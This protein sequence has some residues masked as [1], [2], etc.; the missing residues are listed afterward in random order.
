[1]SLRPCAICAFAM[2]FD[3]RTKQREG[4]ILRPTVDAASQATLRK[5]IHMAALIADGEGPEAVLAVHRVIAWHVRIQGRKTVYQPIVGQT[6][7]SSIDLHGCTETLLAQPIKKRICAERLAGL[8]KG[9]KDS[10]LVDSQLHRTLHG[11]RHAQELILNFMLCYNI[12]NNCI[13]VSLARQYARPGH[14]NGLWD[15]PVPTSIDAIEC[16]SP[17]QGLIF[18]LWARSAKLMIVTK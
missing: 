2:Q 6:L 1:M 17:R 4:F 8:P 16:R 5:L 9:R 15:R 14:V 7:Q 13:G 18:P 3:S 11:S 12:N 10:L